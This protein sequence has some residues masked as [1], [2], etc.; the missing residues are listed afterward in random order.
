MGRIVGLIALSVL[1]WG[2]FAHQ[3][4]SAADPTPGP[5][6]IVATVQHVESAVAARITAPFAQIDQ[7]TTP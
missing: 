5:A 4:P 3:Q 7:Q 6:P 1:L 2:L